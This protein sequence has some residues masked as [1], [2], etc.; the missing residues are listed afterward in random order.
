MRIELTNLKKKFGHVY[1]LDVPSLAITEGEVVGLVGRNGAGKTTMLRL[2]LDL[3]ESDDGS[4]RIEGRNVA[5][6]TTWK[7]NTS[8]YLDESFLIDFLTVD[9]YFHFAA[10][11]YRVPDNQR[12]VSLS[13]YQAFYPEEFFGSTAKLLRDLSKG[14]AKKIGVIGAMFVRPDTLILDEPFANLDPTS[15]IQLKRLILRLNQEH[16]TTCLVS[17]HDLLHV[18]DLCSRIVVLEDGKIAQD[19]VPSERTL[20]E[21]QAYFAEDISGGDRVTV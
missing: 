6:N 20:R 4:V 7:E 17:S 21:L 5:E 14:N 2:I 16:G 11:M 1:A 13:D 15:Q 12:D 8:S 3:L 10:K 19:I 9:E 18:T